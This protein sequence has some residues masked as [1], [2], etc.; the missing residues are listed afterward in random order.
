MDTVVREHNLAALLDTMNPY[1]PIV[2]LDPEEW[3]RNELNIALTDGKGNYG[4]FERAGLGLVSGHYFMKV[5][6]R[7]ALRISK[8]ILKE[9]FTGP[10]DVKVIRGF[11]PLE[12]LGARWMNKKLGFTGYGVLD[13]AVGPMEL[14]ILTKKEW[15]QQ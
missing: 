8:S 12:N 15:E 2:G 4:L 10:Y 13:T 9:V 1:L 6:G 5:R 14:V 11:T 3:L 7:D